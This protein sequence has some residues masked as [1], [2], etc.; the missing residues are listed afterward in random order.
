MAL[1]LCLLGAGTATAQGVGVVQSD[2]L[3][4]NP[5]RLFAET[6]LG[7][8]MNEELQAKRDAL[9]AHNRKLEA[10]LEAEEKA[11][12]ELRAETSPEE[13]RDLADAFDAKVRNIRQDSDRR[14]RDLDRIRSQAPVTFMRLVEP[15]L[16]DIMRDA[17]AAV[18]M[19]SR[20]VLL[21]AEV[22]DIT[23]VAVSRID[24]EIGSELP[25]SMGG[26]TPASDGPDDQSDAD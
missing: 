24:E 22:V 8:T 7:E 1:C 15:V 2:V 6:Q 13:F 11:L 20:S 4:I 19:D 26:G 25:G 5:D 21:R 10:E 12:S 9:I 18:I 17:D 14:A 16:V 3:V 23:D